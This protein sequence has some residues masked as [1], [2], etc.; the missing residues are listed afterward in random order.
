MDAAVLELAGGAA[1]T[2]EFVWTIGMDRYREAPTW[3]TFEQQSPATAAFA[4]AVSEWEAKV[5]EEELRLTAVTR[6]LKPG[7]E[8]PR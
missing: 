3:R 8:T 5:A 2:A 4:A 1:G 7:L 6:P